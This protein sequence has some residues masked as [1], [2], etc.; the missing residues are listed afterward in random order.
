MITTIA[1]KGMKCGG[2]EA[3][4]REAVGACSGVTA[5]APD[6]KSNTVEVEYDEARA[7]LDEIK[8]AIAA[9]G[10]QVG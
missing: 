3:T 1:V 8:Q 2:C 4:V 7:N 5:V 6:H 10:F 9:K